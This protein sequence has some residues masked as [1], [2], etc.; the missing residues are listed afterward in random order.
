MKQETA[1]L[2]LLPVFQQQVSVCTVCGAATMMT[3]VL[4]RVKRGSS[5]RGTSAPLR[6]ARE[7]DKTTIWTLQRYNCRNLLP[8]TAHMTVE[9]TACRISPSAPVVVLYNKCVL[10]AVRTDGNVV[11]LF[12]VRFSLHLLSQK[13]NKSSE[14]NNSATRNTLDRTHPGM[15][16]NIFKVMRSPTIGTTRIRQIGRRARK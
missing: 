9:T 12:Q 4:Y 15:A 5:Q 7:K 13:T 2:L 16:T 8:C 1:I 14:L 6:T 11:T 10:C 3:T